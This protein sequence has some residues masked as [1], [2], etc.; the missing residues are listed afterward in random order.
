MV[1]PTYEELEAQ[2][3]TLRNATQMMLLHATPPHPLSDYALALSGLRDAL[4]TGGKHD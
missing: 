3:Q 4:K 2:L 1:K